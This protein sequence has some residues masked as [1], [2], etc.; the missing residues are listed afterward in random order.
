[1]AVLLAD[2]MRPS[3]RGSNFN[4]WLTGPLWVRT[5]GMPSPLSAVAFGDGSPFFRLAL[6]LTGE[7]KPLRRGPLLTTWLGC[8]LLSLLVFAPPSSAPSGTSGALLVVF[9]PPLRASSS[10]EVTILR[11]LSSTMCTA[12]L[13]VALLVASYTWTRFVLVLQIASCWCEVAFPMFSSAR[14]LCWFTGP[15]LTTTGFATS[16]PLPLPPSPPSPSS[17]GSRRRSLC[18]AS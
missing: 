5:W 6:A 7:T 8:K 13:F 4:V 14:L 11:T 1:M 2:L 17:G 9:S 12:L 16:P 3:L 18:M 15:T 10:V